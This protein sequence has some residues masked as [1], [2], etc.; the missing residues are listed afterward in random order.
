ML[1]K[2]KFGQQMEFKERDILYNTKS[3]SLIFIGETNEYIFLYNN[4]NRETLVFNKSG[5]SGLKIKDTWLTEEEKKAQVIEK[6]KIIK[7][8]F[9]KLNK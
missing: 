4:K 3:D 7:D 9:D 2:S 1:K 5:I 6:Q 8:F